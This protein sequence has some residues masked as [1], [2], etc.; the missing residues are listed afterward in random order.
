MVR[1]FRRYDAEDALDGPMR[2]SP[3]DFIDH[4]CVIDAD[5]GSRDSSDSAFDDHN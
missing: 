4:F 2:M 5:S 3:T 1:H